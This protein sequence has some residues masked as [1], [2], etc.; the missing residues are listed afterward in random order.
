MVFIDG[1]LVKRMIPFTFE[2]GTIPDEEHLVN[3]KP[4]EDKPRFTI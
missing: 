2:L 3:G 4:G 1:V